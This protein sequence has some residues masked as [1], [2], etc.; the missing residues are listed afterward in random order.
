M[1]TSPR[2][3]NGFSIVMVVSEVELSEAEVVADRREDERRNGMG[4]RR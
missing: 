2:K 3:Q 1:V 4:Q